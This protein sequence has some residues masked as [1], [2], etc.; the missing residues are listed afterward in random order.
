VSKLAERIGEARAEGRAAL[1]AYLPVG[2]PMVDDSGCPTATP[3]WT[4]P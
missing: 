4:A 1:I 2:Y 3:A